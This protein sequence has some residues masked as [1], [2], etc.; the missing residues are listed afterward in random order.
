MFFIRLWC[1]FWSSRG[2][3]TIINHTVRL[4]FR[5]IESLIVCALRKIFVD[6]PA[7]WSRAFIWRWMFDI[8]DVS[9]GNHSFMN[10]KFLAPSVLNLALHRKQT[11]T[12]NTQNR[13]NFI[14][15]P[16]R[17]NC[18]DLVD[19]FW[20]MFGE[21]QIPL[22]ILFWLNFDLIS[23]GIPRRRFERT[24]HECFQ[25]ICWVA[26]L[27]RSGQCDNVTFFP[28]PPHASWDRLLTLPDCWGG[29]AFFPAI[30]FIGL[31]KVL[32]RSKCH[33]RWRSSSN[34]KP[35]AIDWEIPCL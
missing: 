14:I 12:Q 19:I 34:P 27:R 35:I 30:D 6:R 21:C 20:G 7:G 5:N 10:D 2:Q 28:H 15:H 22:G 8:F 17:S 29:N 31:P 16:V 33:D 1:R 25:E 18:S 23:H 4:R 11:N 24:A 32:A 9:N 13:I 3:K 26:Y